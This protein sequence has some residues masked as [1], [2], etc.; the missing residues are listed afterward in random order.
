[1]IISRT[2][3]RISFFGGGTDYPIWY[4]KNQGITLSTTINK[5]AYIT[6]RKLP[7]FFE[8]KHR[9]RYFMKEE[10]NSLEEIKHPVVREA[11]KIF[12]IKKGVEMVHT[13]DLPARS[14]LGSSSTFTVGLLMALYAMSNKFV[15]KRELALNAINLEQN[16]I[17]EAV[18]SQ[19]Q[20]IAAFG[21]FNIIDY[22]KS[23]TFQVQEVIISEEKKKSLEEN[24]LLCFTG[25]PRTAEDIAKL[26]IASTDHNEKKLNLMIDIANQAKDV[27][28]NKNISTDEFGKLLNEQWYIKKKLTKLI[29]NNK[30]DSIYD[31]AIKAG[32]IGG[33]LLGAGGGGF[34]LFYAKKENHKKIKEALKDKLFVP[35]RF[36]KTGSQIIYYSHD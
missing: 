34:M 18:G 29:S 2:P 26:Q 16:I 14:G 6:L 12:Q 17:G 19:D 7:P 9:I 1:M 15:T 5:Y 27:L 36:E 25:F 8:F 22:N 20:T 33:K 4:E 32:A 24:L 10:V 30:I 21:G 13:A 31:T 11:L 35:F 28:Y 23:K 3:L